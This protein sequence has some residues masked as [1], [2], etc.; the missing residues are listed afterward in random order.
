MAKKSTQFVM[1]ITGSFTGNLGNLWEWGKGKTEMLRADSRKTVKG[2]FVFAAR[3]MV[4]KG[5]KSEVPRLFGFESLFFLDS[6]DHERLADACPKDILDT[7]DALHLQFLHS[8]SSW[9]RGYKLVEDPKTKEVAPEYHAKLG[10]AHKITI[11]NPQLRYQVR[12]DN[13]GVEYKQYFLSVNN[14]SQVAP[15][16]NLEYEAPTP[17]SIFRFLKKSGA[18]R[19]LA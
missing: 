18:K 2:D 10:R 5:T 1:T 7:E 14:I 17:D 13:D 8:A 19:V 11:T 12:K 3:P 15:M 16:R 4:T 6:D 9:I